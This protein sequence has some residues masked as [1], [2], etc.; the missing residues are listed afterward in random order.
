MISARNIHR[1][2][3]GVLLLASAFGAFAQATTNPAAAG[4]QRDVNQQQRIENGLQSGQ[5]TT[6]EAGALER[7]ETHVDRL[8]ARALTDGTLTSAERAR[9]AAAQDKASRDIAAA[10]HNGVQ[11]H[12]LSASSQRMQASVQRDVN[13]QTRIAQGVQS[14]ALTNRETARLEQGQARVDRREAVAAQDGHVGAREAARLLRAQ[15]RQSRRIHH[16]KT[17]AAHRA[18]A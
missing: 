15:D 5:L 1:H 2:A 9:I 18:P 12:P 4:V 3:A 6:R 10:K 7:D 8:Q 14:G 13:Q 11:G 16:E 17:D